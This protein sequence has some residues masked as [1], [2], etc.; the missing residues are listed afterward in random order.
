ML[1][2]YRLGCRAD[3]LALYRDGH[4]LMVAELGLEPGP[5]LRGLQQ[6]ILGDDPVLLRA[7][8]GSYTAVS[9]R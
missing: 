5:Q 9:G 7:R 6:R 1:A 3:A 2:L 8:N 4:Q